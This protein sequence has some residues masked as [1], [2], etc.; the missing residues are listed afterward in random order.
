MT[1]RGYGLIALCAL[2]LAGTPAALLAAETPRP[3]LF[4]CGRYYATWAGRPWSYDQQCWDHLVDIGATMNGCG[5]AWCD[6]EPTQGSYDMTPVQY[7]DFQVDEMVAR[8]IEPSFFVGLTP[9]W[10]ALRPDLPPHRTPPSESYVTQFQDYCRFIAN[11]YQ[12][13]VHYYFFWN[14]PNGCSWINDG[15]GN[16]DSYPLYTKWLI[17]CSQAIKQVDP[18]AKIIAGNLDY[19]SGVAQG[20]LY[21][22]GMYDNGA[23]PY[24][25]G[26]AIHPY[27]SGGTIHWRAVTDTRNVMVANGDADKGLWLNEY[28]WTGIS[29]EDKSN[30]LTQVLT[31]LKQPEYSY[32]VMACY[33]VLNDGSG[34]EGYGLMD[35]NLNPR[36]SYY[37]FRDFDKSWPD[38]VDFSAD[39]TSGPL[40]LTVQ[41]TDESTVAGAS[42][43]LWEFGDG[44]TS[45]VQNASHQYTED[46]VY[47]VR[48]TV[49]GTGG[50]ETAEKADYIRAGTIPPTPG[51]ANP[52]FEANGGSYD[53]WQIVQVSG[54]GP[55]TPP[56]DNTNPWGPTTPFGTHFGGKITNGLALDFYLGQVIGTSDW[57]P[58]ATDADWTLSA[59]VQ[60]NSTQSGSPNPAGVHQVWEIGWNDDG[61]EPTGITAC[62]HYQVVASIDGNYT[63]NDQVIFYELTGSGTIS[64]VT[65][66]RGVA[67]RAHLYN[68]GTFWWTLD[69]IDN[70]SFVV[71]SAVPPEPPV[72]TPAGFYQAGWNLTSVPVAPY[73][74]EPSAVFQDLVALGNGIDYNLYRYDAGVGYALYPL[75]FSAMERGIGYWLWVDTVYGDTVVSVAGTTATEDVLLSVPEGW[76]LIGHPF[77]QPVPLIDCQVTDGATALGFEDAVL[78]GW[79]SPALYYW[80]PGA[81]YQLLNSAEYADDN[82]LRPWLGYWVH[83]NL[84][85]LQ[86][87][88][89]PPA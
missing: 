20:Y 57:D 14:E 16:A 60:L 15:C 10:A 11:R 27:D 66:L 2:L 55:D 83:S 42:A 4:A 21:V 64:G 78:A 22:Q 37:A 3:F 25:D 73:D 84:P 63:G 31:Q 36:L 32:V 40:P 74:P 41:F 29:E 50:P 86:L 33:L 47:T 67:V 39:V 28:G 35:K 80:E 49:T 85:G 13:K 89:P 58:A 12:G 79:I 75:S 51:V 8:G 61:S 56:L 9:A 30:R 52:S 23:G 72:S 87:I 1:R 59:W 18:N 77:P 6:L 19:H 5:L 43:W 71:S 81:G 70:L 62:D 34:V 68:D 82:T 44:A 38:Y 65:G 53:G 24:I 45:T 48:L 69:N 26:I 76:S 54:E 7:T 17:R 88:V 46:G